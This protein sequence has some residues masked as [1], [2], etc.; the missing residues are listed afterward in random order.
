M[1]AATTSGRMERPIYL[2]LADVILL[3]NEKSNYVI[4]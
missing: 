2:D 4:T 1:A 3:D